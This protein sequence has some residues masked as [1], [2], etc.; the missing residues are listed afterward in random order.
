MIRSVPV[1][2]STAPIIFMPSADRPRSVLYATESYIK[3]LYYRLKTEELA[4][5]I[6]SSHI[7][8]QMTAGTGR[9]TLY[10]CLVSLSMTVGAHQWIG[11][12]IPTAGHV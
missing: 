8:H 12:S 4:K 2:D 9:K 7:P 1:S 10:G 6:T 3:V 5:L 11:H